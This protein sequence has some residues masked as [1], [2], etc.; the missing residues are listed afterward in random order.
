M[1]NFTIMIAQ[2]NLV[3]RFYPRSRTSSGTLLRK[4][5][6]FVPASALLYPSLSAQST[7]ASGRKDDSA[8]TSKYRIV[9]LAGTGHAGYSGDGGPAR[10]AQLKNPFGITRG[11]DGGIYICDMGNHVIRKITPDGNISTV[12]GKGK[13][14][15]SGDGG[16]AKEAEL[17]EPYEIRFGDNGDMFFVEMQNNLVRRVA[18]RTQIIS[19]IAGT[20][21]PGFSGDGGPAASAELNQP[22]SVQ[23]DS[24]GNLYICD[25]GNNRIRKVDMRRGTIS[26]FAGTGGRGRRLMIR[27]FRARH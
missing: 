11:P 4:L 23:L 27:S 26:T 3:R 12:A 7:G 6:V 2:I 16:P 9:T 18:Q 10:E 21:K 24:H 5:L 15:Y 22:H 14:G 17:N 25:I 20:G 1:R 8:L 19:T 13:R